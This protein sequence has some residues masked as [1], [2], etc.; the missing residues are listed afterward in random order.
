MRRIKAICDFSGSGTIYVVG[1]R[2]FWNVPETFESGVVIA[3][4]EQY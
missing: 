1:V 4:S 3:S 2:Y